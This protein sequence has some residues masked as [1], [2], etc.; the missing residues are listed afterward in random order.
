MR[1]PGAASCPTL[2]S[3]LL[4]HRTEAIHAIDRYCLLFVD[5]I[6]IMRLC[7]LCRRSWQGASKVGSWT[8][9]RSVFR[10]CPFQVFEKIDEWIY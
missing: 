10:L 5:I 6:L 4:L 2:I 9:S 1:I 8:R 3:I 7:R